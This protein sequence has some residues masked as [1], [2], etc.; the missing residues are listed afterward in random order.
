MGRFGDSCEYNLTIMQRSLQIFVP[1]MGCVLLA[2]WLAACGGRPISVTQT[3]SAIS[4][5]TPSPTETETPPTPTPT[6]TPVPLAARVNEEALTLEEFQAELA[7]FEA[8]QGSAEA[9]DEANARDRVLQDL[10]SQMLLAQGAREAGYTIDDATLRTRLD[11]LTVSIGGESALLT[12]M[13]A[14]QFTSESLLKGLRRSME[15]AWMR[16][17]ILAS[18]PKVAEQTH[19][20]QIFFFNPDQANEALAQLDSGTDFAELAETYNPVSSGDLGWFPRGFLTEP[21]LEE[22]AFSLQPG[23]HSQVIETELGYHIL[24]V[25]ERD[26]QRPLDP[27]AYFVQQEHALRDWLDVRRGQSEIEISLP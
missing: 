2:V 16:D 3:Q 10:I 1:L 20:R 26:A 4:S 11:Q 18:V 8:A 7:R 13:E 5:D 25:I 22:A 21:T 14:N 6:L 27:Q 23:E 9:V 24:Q 17:Q 19:A 12:W 15:A